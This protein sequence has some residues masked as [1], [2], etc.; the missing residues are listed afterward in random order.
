MNGLSRFAD[1]LLRLVGPLIIIAAGVGALMVFGQR[2]EAAPRSSTGEP[3][4]AVETAVVEADEGRFI[5]EVDGVAVPYRR[6]THSAEVSGR[7]TSKVVDCRAGHYVEAGEFLLEIDPTDYQWDVDRFTVQ[8]EQADENLAE[9][10][11]DLANTGPLIELAQ[12]ELRLQRQNLARVERLMSNNA[13]TDTQLDT[14]RMQE[15]ASRNALQTLEN[16]RSALRQRKNTL[17]A[18]KK[19][20]KTELERAR[21]NLSRTRVSAPLSGTLVSVEVEEGD[22]VKDGDP[23]FTIN[24]TDTME[25][26]CQLRVDELYWIWL[27]AGTFGVGSASEQ[28]P[29]RPSVTEDEASIAVV[30]TAGGRAGR[31]LAVA[32]NRDAMFEI[33]NVAVEVAF[34]FREAEYLWSGVLS[35]YDGT[36]LDPSTRTVPCRVRVDAPTDVRVGGG[37]LSGPVAPPTLFSGMYVK[38]RIPIDVPLPLLRVPLTALQPGEEVWVIRNEKLAVVPVRTARKDRHHAWLSVSKDGPQAG[39]R[40]VTSP[41]AAVVDGMPVRDLGS[42]ETATPASGAAASPATEDR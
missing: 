35:R 17:L 42:P 15:L 11:I 18:A 4:V 20:A 6:V 19:L 9:V 32:D 16:R 26:S 5:L 28:G 33:P 34:P 13:T 8:I 23:L 2:P 27:Q 12:E 25:V 21:I 14:A 41:L 40:V 3:A 24:D 29:G 1:E 38:V 39:E 10:E 31:E 37:G 22:Y 7:I 36:G 30:R